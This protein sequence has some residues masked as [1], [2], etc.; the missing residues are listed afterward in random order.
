M[1][2]QEYQE[3]NGWQ[4][5]VGLDVPDQ[6]S[7]GWV[8]TKFGGNEVWIIGRNVLVDVAH[9]AGLNSI[10]TEAVSA[11]QGMDG[12]AYA[13]VRST[14]DID[15][16]PTCSS[17]G[18][19]DEPSNSLEDMFSTAE[20]RATKRAIKA[21]LNIR[22]P[23]APVDDEDAKSAASDSG[24]QVR[25]ADDGGVDIDPPDEYKSDEGGGSEDDFF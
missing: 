7:D 15:G 20:T 18:S 25:R 9:Q 1:S 3:V 11:G 24:G 21:A 19:I 8:R 14:V 17:I 10:E 5:P 13:A 6:S 22:N 4:F 16:Y 12:V 2:D 23:G